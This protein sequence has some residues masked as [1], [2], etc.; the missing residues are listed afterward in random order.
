MTPRTLTR[1]ELN[2]AILQRQLLLRRERVSAI[3]VME[4]LVGM[5]AQVPTDP[6][7]GLW[8]RIGDFDPL[9]LSATSRS[10]GSCVR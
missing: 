3:E 8:S 4:R 7:T 6:Y 5:Q 9:E 1:R 2:R 10:D